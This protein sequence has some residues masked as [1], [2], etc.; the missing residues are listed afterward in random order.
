MLQRFSYRNQAHTADVVVDEAVRWKKKQIRATKG[1]RMQETM[2]FPHASL[3]L[4]QHLVV[5]ESLSN[6]SRTLGTEGVVPK[7]VQQQRNRQG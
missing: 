5:R 4:S 1:N 7:A 3:E 6:R 2:F